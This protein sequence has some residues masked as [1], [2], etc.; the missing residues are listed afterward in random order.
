MN[1]D[2]TNTTLTATLSGMAPFTTLYKL[3]DPARC[4]LAGRQQ[5][6]PRETTVAPPLEETPPCAGAE[7]ITFDGRG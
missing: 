4:S 5:P 2:D 7:V 6:A 1:I 3:P